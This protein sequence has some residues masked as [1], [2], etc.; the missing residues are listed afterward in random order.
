M[1]PWASLIGW[2]GALALLFAV[3]SFLLQFVQ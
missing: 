3:L 2:L 1:K